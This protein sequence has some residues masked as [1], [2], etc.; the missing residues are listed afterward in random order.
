MAKKLIKVKDQTVVTNEYGDLRHELT[1][2]VLSDEARLAVSIIEKWAMVTSQGG[3]AL[4]GQ[5][6]KPGE[7]VERAFDIAHLTMKHI[8]ANK[9]DAPFPFKKVF[10]D[11]AQ[12]G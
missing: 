1:N 12:N 6:L 9:L 4:Q 11:D 8:R 3:T 10:G 5:L 2:R 7:V